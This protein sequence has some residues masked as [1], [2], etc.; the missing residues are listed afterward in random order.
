MF[1][2]STT[3]DGAVVSTFMAAAWV[4][5]APGADV[6]T[7]LIAL[8]E[9]Q[10]C[11][12]PADISGWVVET[13]GRTRVEL[14]ADGTGYEAL[15]AVVVDFLRHNTSGARALV[16]LDHDEYGAEHI[17]LDAPG[18][19]VRRVHHVFVYPRD[20]DTN[21]PY[22]EGEPTLTEV[23]AASPPEPGDDPGAL[24]DGPQARV[25][26]ARLYEVPSERV[27]AAAV[28]AAH[29][30]ESLQIVGAPFSPWLDAFNLAW[31][32]GTG[33]RAVRLRPNE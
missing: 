19:Q 11:D 17:V 6:D 8:R 31:V 16:A 24:V 13:A 28:K 29:A 21:E 14:V 18:G 26:A 22:L 20:E 1:H 30:H 25:V 3:P 9:A 32:G 10:P 7:A 12:E 33:G 4:D 5:L 2:W 27:E 23:P 15:A